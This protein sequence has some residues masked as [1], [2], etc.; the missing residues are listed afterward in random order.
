M[1]PTGGV[2]LMVGEFPPSLGD[3]RAHAFHVADGLQ[4]L[5]VTVRV[6]CPSQHITAQAATAFDARA[7]FG[8]RP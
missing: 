5:G 1:E 4:R 7:P 2:I 8:D 3:I 6:L